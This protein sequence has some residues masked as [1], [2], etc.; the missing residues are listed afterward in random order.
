M[1]Q[2]KRTLHLEASIFT[3][4]TTVVVTSHLKLFAF[5]PTY[6]ELRIYV[7]PMWDRETMYPF[8][9][10]CGDKLWLAELKEA[11]AQINISSDGITYNRNSEGKEY[12]ILNVDES[13][14]RDFEQKVS[15]IAL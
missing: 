4:E 6:G 7:D 15:V 13:F 1:Y 10:I 12:M 14:I 2:F 9:C 8:G 3:N 5:E 11:F